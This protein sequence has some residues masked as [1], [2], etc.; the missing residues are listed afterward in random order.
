MIIYPVRISFTFI[1]SFSSPFS[2]ICKLFLMMIEVRSKR[3]ITSSISSSIGGWERTNRNRFGVLK[4]GCRR[5]SRNINTMEFTRTSWHTVGPEL[6][7]S[8][9]VTMDIPLRNQNLI[10]IEKKKEFI[11]CIYLPA[12]F[13]FGITFCRHNTIQ[14][15][16]FP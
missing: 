15:S 1:A 4:G 12:C 5:G 9:K 6:T 16:N 2:H 13:N 8:R 14:F 3:S 11:I 7:S 10:E